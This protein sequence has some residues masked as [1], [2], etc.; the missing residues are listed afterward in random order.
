MRNNVEEAELLKAELQQKF[1]NDK[2]N[3]IERLTQD[4]EKKVKN[5]FLQNRTKAPPMSRLEKE[6][7]SMKLQAEIEIQQ[8][9]LM[10]KEKEY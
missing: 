1:E 3:M 10:K 6:N 7:K 9:E 5:Q 4:I 2:K 8:I